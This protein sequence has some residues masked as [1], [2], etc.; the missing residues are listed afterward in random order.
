MEHT[1]MTAGEEGNNQEYSLFIPFGSPQASGGKKGN[2]TYRLFPYSPC[3][4][5]AVKS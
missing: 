4:F 5:A 3:R 1:V 2:N